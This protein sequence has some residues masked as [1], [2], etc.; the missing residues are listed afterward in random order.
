MNRY[1]M[2][3]VDCD[4]D[5]DGSDPSLFQ[6]WEGVK[7]LQYAVKRLSTPL[8]VNLRCDCGIKI[9]SLSLGSGY[10]LTQ[11]NLIECLKSFGCS[12]GVHYHGYNE[13]FEIDW[14]EQL[15]MDSLGRVIEP[16]KVSIHTG[17]CNQSNFSRYAAYGFKLNYFPLP[18]AVGYGH[19]YSNYPNKPQ[20]IGNMLVLPTQTIKTRI[21][22][23]YNHINPVHPTAPNWLF[24][25]L[26]KAFEQTDNNTLCC[27]FHADELKG[28]T[29]WRHYFYNE[30]NLKQNIDYLKSREY[31]FQNAEQVYERFCACRKR[32]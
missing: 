8:A 28:I 5:R 22:R 2:I 12:V 21:G 24:R 6:F 27:Y 19:D 17:W 9:E 7:N 3:G 10:W 30:S 13:S 32:E 1:C 18:G 25:R 23:A 26:V 31:V 14:D 15:I 16:F 29:G 4:P 20:W 11:T